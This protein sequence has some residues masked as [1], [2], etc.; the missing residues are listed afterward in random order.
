[1]LEVDRDKYKLDFTGRFDQGNEGNFGRAGMSTHERLTLRQMYEEVKSEAYQA[2][3]GERGVETLSR[4]ERAELREQIRAGL[5]ERIVERG[6]QQ[7][8]VGLVGAEEVAE[9]GVE[10]A[11]GVAEYLVEQRGPEA[12]PNTHFSYTTK[13]QLD[14]FVWRRLVK[15]GRIRKGGDLYDEWYGLQERQKGY[16]NPQVRYP[17]GVDDSKIY[18]VAKPHR[19]W[20]AQLMRYLEAIR[21]GRVVGDESK[22]L[23]VDESNLTAYAIRWAEFED[24]FEAAGSVDEI[25]VG[26]AVKAMVTLKRNGLSDEQVITVLLAG[27]SPGGPVK[28]HGN[29]PQVRK[30]WK[31]IIAKVE[32]D[33]EIGALAGPLRERVGQKMKQVGYVF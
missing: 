20:P 22:N 6:W 4:S 18:G 7:P 13:N 1:M 24:V 8:E 16:F 26:I 9:T 31:E 30:I 25:A 10:H 11:C 28:E 32:D 15:L 12:G 14:R 5:V 27:Y 23:K 19:Y 33:E 29:I 21:L 3:F 2:L 17:A